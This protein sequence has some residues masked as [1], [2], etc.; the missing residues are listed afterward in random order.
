MEDCLT[1][2]WAATLCKCICNIQTLRGGGNIPSPLLWPWPYVNPANNLLLHLLDSSENWDTG[3]DESS[4]RSDE[5]MMCL[6]N[7]A[8]TFLSG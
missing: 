8:D 2:I 6:G 5:G 1:G 3:S 4:G 7:G